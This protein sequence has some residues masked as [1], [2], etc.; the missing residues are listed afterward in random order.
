[1]PQAM[2]KNQLKPR[3]AASEARQRLKRLKGKAKVTGDI[4]SPSGI[5]WNAERDETLGPIKR[6]R[7]N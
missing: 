1:M 6:S 7:R 2:R 4:L 3:S 5:T